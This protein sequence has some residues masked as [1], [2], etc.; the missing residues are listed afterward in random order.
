MYD[1]DVRNRCI[2]FAFW[3]VSWRLYFGF[4]LKYSSRGRETRAR[5]IQGDA[6][7]VRFIKRQEKQA[8]YFSTVS[9]FVAA[10]YLQA[11]V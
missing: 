3:K 5:T 6:S 9:G 4:S 1:M 8:L 11:N 7:G 2:T 10:F